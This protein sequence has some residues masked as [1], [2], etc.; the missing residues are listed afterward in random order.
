MGVWVVVCE[1]CRTRWN[2][3]GRPAEY[4]R[5]AVESRPCPACGAYTLSCRELRPADGKDSTRRVA[6]RLR[7]AA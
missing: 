4:E 5:Q 2:R 1:S 6:S 7:P 3:P